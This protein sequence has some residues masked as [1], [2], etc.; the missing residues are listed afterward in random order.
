MSRKGGGSGAHS[1]LGGGRTIAITQS[2]H[3]C[4][5]LCDCCYQKY[6]RHRSALKG[7]RQ[8]DGFVAVEATELTPEAP[9]LVPSIKDAQTS[10]RLL[11][12][13]VPVIPGIMASNGGCHG[14]AVCDCTSSYCTDKGEASNHV[15]CGVMASCERLFGPKCM[16]CDMDS[17]LFSHHSFLCSS[18][19]RGT[20]FHSS[21]FAD[22][23]CF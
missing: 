18:V 9:S 11:W 5:D 12:S 7:W 19:V 2:I 1:L 10:L 4:E 23:G 20:L 21:I 8:F 17:H 3:E 16:G 6:L 13:K 14:G 22:F 15:S